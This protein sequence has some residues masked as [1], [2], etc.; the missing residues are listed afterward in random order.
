M[1]RFYWILCTA[2]LGSYQCSAGLGCTVQKC[3]NGLT[4]NVKA[5]QRLP[6]AGSTNRYPVNICA[7][8][9][10]SQLLPA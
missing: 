2:A 6:P 4:V 1:D 7:A 10:L 9:V 5:D 3:E 8:C